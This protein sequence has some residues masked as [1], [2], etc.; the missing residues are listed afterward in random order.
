MVVIILFAFGNFY[1]L[2]NENMKSTSTAY[3]TEYTNHGFIDAMINSYFVSLGEFS[4]DNFGDGSKYE[5]WFIWGIF[6][7]ETFLGCVVFMNML[8]AIM[9]ETFGEVQAGAVEN[10]LQEQLNMMSDHIWLLDLQKDFKGMKYIIRVAPPSPATAPVVD[11]I[12][13]LRETKQALM[14]SNKTIREQCQTNSAQIELLTK[15]YNNNQSVLDSQMQSILKSLKEADERAKIEKQ[16][17]ENKKKLEKEAAEAKKKE[18]EAKAK[19][20]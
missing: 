4:Y 9:G 5:K 13:F 20:D 1:Y 19:Q 3:I 17:K 14:D 11:Q 6:L 8:I 12:D 18:E 7:M 2:I 16:E 10:G 15:T